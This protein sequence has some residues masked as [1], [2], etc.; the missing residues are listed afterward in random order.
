MVGAKVFLGLVTST[1]F[2]AHY[3]ANGWTRIQQIQ[4]FSEWQEAARKAFLARCDNASL[5]DRNLIAEE[6]RWPFRLGL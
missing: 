1:V 6:I 4:S 3:L 5:R 2:T